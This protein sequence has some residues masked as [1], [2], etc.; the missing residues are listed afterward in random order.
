M[1]TRML[2]ARGV[3]GTARLVYDRC[4]GAFLL[5]V[6]VMVAMLALQHAN[7]A[8]GD[9]IPWPKG[10][11]A[12]VMF[13]LWANIGDKLWFKQGGILNFFIFAFLRC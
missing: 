5:F 6:A 12:C 10:I 2:L 11:Q 8:M 13:V 1:N 7:G 9:V 3:A 4:C